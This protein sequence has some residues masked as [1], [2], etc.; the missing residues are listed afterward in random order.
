MRYTPKRASAELNTSSVAD[1]AF[2]LL[3]FFLLTT[4]IAD[5]KG[6]A[7]SLP[8]WYDDPPISPVN[9]RNIFKIQVNYADQVM[10]Q[11]KT[12]QDLSGVKA[13]LKGFILNYGSDPSSSQDPEK[14]IIS[15]K[16]DRGTSHNAYIRVLDVVQSAYNE[17]Y[18]SRVNL[19]VKDYLKLNPD[20]PEQKRIIQK[21]REGLPMNISIAEPTAAEH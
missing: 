11:G 2:L 19:S 14:A 1:I 20:M 8:M 17:I 7:I 15:I 3:T 21:A 6:L 4:V 18:A 5:E 10:V 12:R 16:T 13:E 9:E